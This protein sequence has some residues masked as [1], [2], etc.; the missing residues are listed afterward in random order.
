MAVER[1][2]RQHTIPQFFLKVW[3]YDGQVDAIDRATR[4]ILPMSVKNASVE[5]YFHSP[6]ELE[7]SGDPDF[8][9]NGLANFEGSVASAIRDLPVAAWPPDPIL[10][11]TAADFVAMMWARSPRTRRII[12]E[13]GSPVEWPA[14]SGYDPVVH[15]LRH[16]GRADEEFDEDATVSYRHVTRIPHMFTAIRPHVAN[17]SWLRLDFDDPVLLTGDSPVC[18]ASH[19]RRPEWFGDQIV[20]AFTIAVSPRCALVLSLQDEGLPGCTT[21]DRHVIGTSDDAAIINGWTTEFAERWTFKHPYGEVKVALVADSATRGSTTIRTRGHDAI[22][23]VTRWAHRTGFAPNNALDNYYGSALTHGTSEKKLAIPMAQGG[24][25]RTRP[26][27][28]TRT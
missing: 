4:E 15:A 9:E 25:S 10:R 28:K 2:V 18:L 12:A 16:S 23:S 27:Q 7:N 17:A 13:G 26:T 6:D 24:P 1:K 3:A 19:F 20:R 21:D 11:A 8:M 14:G 5:K 22:E